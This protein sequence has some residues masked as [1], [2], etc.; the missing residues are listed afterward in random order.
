MAVTD[1]GLTV[2]ATSYQWQV[3]LDGGSTFTNATGTGNNTANYTPTE[4]DEGGLLKVNVTYTD[5]VNSQTTSTTSNTSTAIADADDLVATLS[6]TSVTEGTAVGVAVTDNGLTVTA[7]SYQWQVSP[8][9]GSTFT[10]AT[11]T[12]NNTA[13]YT[14]TEGD[15]GGL[16]KVNVTYTDGVN[17]QTTSTTSNTS[18]A[19]ADADDLVA[20]LSTTSVTEGDG[21]RRGRDR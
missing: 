13:S 19:I 3:S 1:N 2:T 17:S 12:G 18:T 20:T 15:E 11:G 4:G 10:N 16:L 14:P 21:G 9:G 8:D 7:T 6:T 5:G